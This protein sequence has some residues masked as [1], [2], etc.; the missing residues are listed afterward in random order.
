[1]RSKI[2]LKWLS[3]TL[4]SMTVLTLPSGCVGGTRHVIQGA[5][6]TGVALG[7]GTYAMSDK[8]GSLAVGKLDNKELPAGTLILVPATK[9]EVLDALKAA[10]VKVNEEKKP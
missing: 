6:R 8:D 1:M 5:G 4:L 10:G 3:L 9:Q 7:D 2:P